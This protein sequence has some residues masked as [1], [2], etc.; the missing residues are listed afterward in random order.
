MTDSP[1]YF[2]GKWVASDQDK[3]FIYALAFR[4]NDPKKKPLVNA[5]SIR[6]NND[7][8][9][10]TSQQMDKIVDVILDAGNVYQQIFKTASQLKE[11]TDILIEANRRMYHALSDIKRI[12]E[13]TKH[14]P[15]YVA[16]VLQK[17]SSALEEYHAIYHPD[18]TPFGEKK[19]WEIEQHLELELEEADRLMKLHIRS[20][21]HDG[22]I[23]RQLFDKCQERIMMLQ[24]ALGRVEIKK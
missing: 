3:R 16:D 12:S 18:P 9:Q 22:G 24:W 11:T 1:K 23:Y 19:R 4:A 21:S 15:A 13:S 8:R 6:V 17:T 5:F 7:N 20:P 14:D 10:L 2:P